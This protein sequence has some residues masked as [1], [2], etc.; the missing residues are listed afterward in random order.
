VD[1]NS[2]LDQFDFFTGLE[3]EQ[4]SFIAAN[5]TEVKAASGDLLIRQ[6]QVGQDVYLLENGS[7]SVFRGEAASPTSSQMILGAP[8]ILGEMAMVDP[9]RIR[10]SSVIA[11]SDLRL[12]KIP[13]ATFL[14]FVQSYPSLKEKLRETIAARSKKA[15]PRLN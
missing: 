3:Q 7:V 4:L 9:E 12:L 10:T 8:T 11:L 14:I 13:I 15:S 6:G 5:C 2:R 1:T